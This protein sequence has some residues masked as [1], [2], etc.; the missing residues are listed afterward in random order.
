[1]KQAKKKKGGGSRGKEKRVTGIMGEG[2]TH[3]T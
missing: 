1:M 2:K 3:S